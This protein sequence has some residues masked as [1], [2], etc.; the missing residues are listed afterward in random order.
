MSKYKKPLNKTEK[1]ERSENIKKLLPCPALLTADVDEATETSMEFFIR[2][3]PAAGAHAVAVLTEISGGRYDT[4]PTSLNARV[5]AAKVLL[6]FAGGLVE[7]VEVS[8]ER[9]H[10]SMSELSD[11]ELAKIV[12]RGK[13]RLGK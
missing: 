11:E 3:R 7:R 9:H 10:G 13:A 6:Q 4:E 5:N 1:K 2:A 8:D 12:A